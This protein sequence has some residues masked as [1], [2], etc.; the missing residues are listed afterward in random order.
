MK[1]NELEG[2][3][4]YA[5]SYTITT[6]KESSALFDSVCQVGG[7]R[8]WFNSNWM[9]RARGGFDR[10]LFGVGSARGRKNY[11]VLRTNDVIDFWRVEELRRECRLLLR[12]EM[13]LPG[14]AWL[15]FKIDDEGDRRR[16]TITAFFHPTGLFGRAYWYAFLPFHYFIFNDL[17]AQIERRAQAE[18][19]S[20]FLASA[21][22]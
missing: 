12:A 22:R 4:A 21:N 20:G 6:T 2:R 19:R 15:E 7:Q 8:G 9:W 10:I 16:F 1:L 18:C 17:L 3:P 13:K 11:P 14:K 5:K